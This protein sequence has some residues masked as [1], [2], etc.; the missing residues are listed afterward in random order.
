MPLPV[1]KA[2]GFE[3]PL[4]RWGVYAISAVAVVGVSLFLYQK[5]YNDPE[6]ALLSLKEVNERMQFEVEEY[7]QHVMEE[8]TKHELFED[9]DGALAVR[10]YKDHCVLI[11]R[12]TRYGVRTR[13]VPD[14]ARNVKNVLSRQI[15]PPSTW[16]ILPTVEAAQACNRGCIP[17]ERHPGNFQWWYGQ[18]RQDGWVEVWRRYQDG[19]THV[20]MF[21]PRFGVWDSNPNG[22]PRVRWTCC[23]H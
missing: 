19:C 6:R 5:F 23:V 22:T 16:N 8:P 14:L 20:Q 7:G 15:A 4:S 13:L 11:Q 21:N 10:I 12:R 1:L 2:F 9:T 18:Q 3:I 17:P